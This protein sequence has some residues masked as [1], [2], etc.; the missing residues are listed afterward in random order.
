MV[1]REGQSFRVEIIDGQIAVGMND[2]GARSFLD[3]CGIDAVGKP[4]FDDDGVTKITFG[5][6]EQVANGC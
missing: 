2:D 6:R 1:G 4:F 3:R 5:L